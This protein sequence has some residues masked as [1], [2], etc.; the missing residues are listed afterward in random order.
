MDIEDKLSVETLLISKVVDGVGYDTIR[1]RVVFAIDFTIEHAR[2][3]QV[4][5]ENGVAVCQNSSK[6][7]DFDR[8]H[9]FNVHARV[10]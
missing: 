7:G 2:F 5:F 8:Q 6:F 3:Y 10:V 1:G 9:L 4:I